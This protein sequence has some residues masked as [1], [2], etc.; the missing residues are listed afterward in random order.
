VLVATALAVPLWPWHRFSAGV[1]P[2]LAISPD[3]LWSGIWPV[4]VGCVIFAAHSATGR[5][6]LRFPA[7]DVLLPIERLIS[8][9]RPAFSRL[10]AAE[11]IGAIE[12]SRLRYVLPVIETIFPGGRQRPEIPAARGASLGLSFLL[13][14]ILLFSALWAGL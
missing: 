6:R 14:L 9:I 8:R 4:L 10:A 1:S 2:A 13:I 5:P 3:K 11:V 7:G 12:R